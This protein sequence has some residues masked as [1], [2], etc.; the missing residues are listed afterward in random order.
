M[1][2]YD[3]AHAPNPRRV[4][5]FLAEKNIEVER[6]LVDFA[7]GEQFSPEF[8]SL[9]PHAYL[10]CL[11]L[12]DGRA[13]SESTAICRYFEA[14]KPEPPLLGRNPV[15]QGLVEMWLRRVAFHAYQPVAD[16]YRNASKRFVDRALPGR[17]E[18][19]PQIPALVDRANDSLLH[20][21]G[22]LEAH[23]EKATFL[24]DDY[25]SFADISLLVTIDFARAT[26]MAASERFDSFPHL[27]R[28]HG[29][30]NARPSSRA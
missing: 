7:K 13:I 3:H 14:L 11:T 5:I 25:F 12:D 20:F 17:S 9:N 21:L 10:P 6:V 2:L 23:L 15:E 16:A 26:R 8:L 1:K 19:V 24:A 28:W 22:G 4:R 29:E 27:Q 18:G 30:I